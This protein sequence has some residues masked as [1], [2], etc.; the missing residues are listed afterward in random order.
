MS[1]PTKGLPCAVSARAAAQPDPGHAREAR[2]VARRKR[3]ARRIVD[4]TVDRGR[5]RVCARRLLDRRGVSRPTSRRSRDGGRL[6]LAPPVSTEPEAFQVPASAMS[7]SR[8]AA[9]SRTA[10]ASQA[11]AAKHSPATLAK[12][13]NPIFLG[14]SVRGIQGARRGTRDASP[15]V[16]RRSHQGTP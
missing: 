9:E 11:S 4:L 13:R 15:A 1:R 5:V 8:A 7:K 3:S 14:W 10:V 12:S 16:R 6:H 2:G